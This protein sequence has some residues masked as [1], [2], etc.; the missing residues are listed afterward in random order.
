MSETE[1]P[2]TGDLVNVLIVDDTPSNLSLLSGILRAAGHTVRMANSPRR[3]LAMVDAL[4]PEL[5]IG[6]SIAVDLVKPGKEEGQ[7]LGYLG[8]GSMVVVNKARAFVGKRVTAEI[9]GVLPSAGGKMI[10]ATLLGEAT[11]GPS[12]VSK[13]VV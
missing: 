4:R 5:V 11:A 10:F 12:S 13:G 6:E 9:I 3:A 1:Q 8:D 7:A 2:P